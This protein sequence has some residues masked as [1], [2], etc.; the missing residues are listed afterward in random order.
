MRGNKLK[1][2][3]SGR[4]LAARVL[5]TGPGRRLVDGLVRLA[6]EPCLG[7]PGDPDDPESLEHRRRIQAVLNVAAG[8]RIVYQPIVDLGSLQVVGYEALSRFDSDRTAEDWYD[9]AHAVGL[10]VE[11]EMLAISRAVADPPPHGYLSVNVSPATLASDAFRE[12]LDERLWGRLVVELTEHVGIDDYDSLGRTVTRLRDRGGRLAVDDAGGGYASLRHVVSLGP[13]IIKIDR[14][15]IASMDRD[16]GRR[17]LAR[18][19]SRFAHRTGASL[20]AEGIE[21]PEEYDTCRQVGIDCGQGYLFGA[22]APLERLSRQQ[23]VLG[24][25]G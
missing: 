8:L 11:L 19:L 22:P 17:E 25:T 15:L 6:G 18:S 21:R 4:R 5:A 12:F 10:G 1:D 16:S 13:D 20:V 23:I 9:E 7:P 3:G 2:R 14:S 24:P